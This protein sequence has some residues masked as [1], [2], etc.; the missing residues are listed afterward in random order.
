MALICRNFR[1]YILLAL[2]TLAGALPSSAQVS[3]S[4]ISLYLGDHNKTG[5]LIVRNTSY[6]PVEVTVDLIFAYPATDENGEI[7]LR[8]FETV[9][10]GEPSATE[11]IRVYPPR[12][13]LPPQERQVIRIAAR[14]PANL[15]DGEYWAR[16]VVSSRGVVLN[17]GAAGSHVSAQLNVVKRMFLALK[18]RH[19]KVST[20]AAIQYAEPRVAGDTLKL[21]V[22]INRMGNAAYLGYLDIQILDRSGDVQKELRKQI[23]VYHQLHSLFP[24]YIGDLAPGSYTARITL[25][26]LSRHKEDAYVLKAPGV[27]ETVGFVIPE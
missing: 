19:G 24:F 21:A 2:F 22:D 13:V 12:V 20:A 25:D 8:T 5:R 27:T 15:P 4:P 10:P 18:Y 9:P 16:P 1:I 14:P 3:V 23:A 6:Q 7:H 11:W 17:S 26:A